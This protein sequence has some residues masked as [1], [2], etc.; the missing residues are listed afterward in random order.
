MEHVFRKQ[1]A[2]DS[3]ASRDFVPNQPIPHESGARVNNPLYNDDDDE[4]CK[5]IT[6]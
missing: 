6:Y 4:L 2:R 1:D 3:A 5:P